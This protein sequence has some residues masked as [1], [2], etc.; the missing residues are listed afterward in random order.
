VG[1]Q[2]ALDG[3]PA[4][5]VFQMPPAQAPKWNTILFTGSPET[6]TTRPPREGPMQRHFSASNPDEAGMRVFRAVGK[7]MPIS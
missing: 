6:A 2:V 4:S 1:R 3:F 7:G 5:A